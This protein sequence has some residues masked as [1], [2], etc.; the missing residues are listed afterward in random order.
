MADIR[1]Q[2]TYDNLGLTRDPGVQPVPL[3]RSTRPALIQIVQLA[4]SIATSSVFTV[5]VDFIVTAVNNSL[6]AARLLLAGAR[7]RYTATCALSVACVARAKTCV[8]FGS[9]VFWFFTVLLVVSTVNLS[10][11]VSGST[12]VPAEPLLGITS[13]NGACHFALTGSSASAQP[14]GRPPGNCGRQPDG[15]FT[16]NRT[17]PSV[18]SSIAGAEI[19]GRN[20]TS[21]ANFPPCP[22]PKCHNDKDS[23]ALGGWLHWGIPIVALLR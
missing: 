19:A 9:G 2:P 5:T 16:T 11:A 20:S 1:L 21:D 8:A 14:P 12:P 15:W 10:V 6:T 23:L 7:E 18:D 17:G 13:I 3:S 22:S 4:L